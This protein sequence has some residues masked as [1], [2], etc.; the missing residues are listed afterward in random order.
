MDAYQALKTKLRSISQLPR[1]AQAAELPGVL[2]LLERYLVDTEG[3][4]ARL[5]RLHR[6]GGNHAEA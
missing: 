5:E 2:E 4:L 3:R 6:P 1:L